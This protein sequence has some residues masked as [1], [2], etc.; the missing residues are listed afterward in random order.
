MEKSVL[1]W[2]GPW[3][4]KLIPQNISVT[5][6]TASINVLGVY[7]GNDN[8]KNNKE[9]FR[10]QLASMRNNINM[11]KFRNL[12]LIGKITLSESTGMSNLIY[13]M[14]MVETP[15]N[16]I[17]ESQTKLNKFIWGNYPP[18]VIYKSL[19]ASYEKGGLKAPDIVSKGSQISMASPNHSE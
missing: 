5:I 16:I 8:N 18:R 11:W 12:T 19:V 4:Q 14:S 1:Y 15:Q 9:N 6:E 3:K 13:S 17:N 10:V 7:I 2:V